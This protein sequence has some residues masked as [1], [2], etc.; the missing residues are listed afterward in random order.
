MARSHLG[1]WRRLGLITAVALLG[2]S[3]IS[4]ASLAR[5][6]G[7]DRFRPSGDG[8][9][10]ERAE[11]AELR[12]LQEMEDQAAEHP[13]TGAQSLFS[14]CRFSPFSDG[15]VTYDPLKPWERDVIVDDTTTTF[16]DGTTCYNPQNEQN[17]VV[18][19]T[20]DKNVVTSSNDYRYGS[21]V[22]Y[23]YVSDDGGASW[24]NVMLPGWTA[25]TGGQG[26]FAKSYCG[27]DPVLAFG[28]DG[29]L[30]FA[31]LVY[32]FDK[33]PRTLSGVAVSSSSDGGHTWTAPVM[34]AYNGTGNFFYDKE[35]I[36]VGNDGT[37]YLT[38]TK[39]YQGPL[40][41]G[42]LKSP[43]VMASSRNG[44]KSWSSVKEVSDAAHPYN[45]GSQVLQAPDGALYVAYEGATP[46]SGYNE[47]ALIVAR[48]TD[49]GTHFANAEVARV[50]DDY[51]C[52]PIQEPGGQDRQ[53]LS[54]MQLRINSY[55]SM[56]I[57]PA[58]GQIVIVWA[59]NR[60]DPA[61]GHGGAKYTGS[62]TSNQV[63][64]VTSS[65]GTGWS[66]VRQLTSG[67]D[68][69]YPSVG[70]NNG[71]IAIGYYTREYATSV[72]ANRECGIME[73]DTTT[74]ELVPPTDAGRASAVVC[75]D[76]AL[77]TSL[78]DFA[79]TTRV[80]SQSSN[81]YILFSGSFIGDYEGTAVTA[82]G[83]IY[84]T[85]TDFRGNPGVTL[86]NQDTMVGVIPTAD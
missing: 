26:L 1:P 20:N 37:V 27:G 46:G 23:A 52:Y 73:R 41:L 61:C 76:W 79:G 49:G 67:P 48:S 58:T 40:G 83:T 7:Q 66:A 15:T 42:Y 34:V 70:V 55:P 28:P 68:K 21:Y 60:A 43:I 74:G 86:P 12:N 62:G 45:Q 84:T 80:S 31:G 78:D 4:G 16:A 69:V 81:P 50:Y 10:G 11:L 39:F 2:A 19:P 30:Y 65:D 5:S 72:G 63:Q 57:D 32:N 29:T 56:A 22:C 77:K 8:D 47:D 13:V 33:F 38:W 75:L 44:G 71:L 17:I 14:R 6:P 25:P 59:D 85:W 18:N 54:N 53:T 82:D 35:W 3:T 64:M 51:D 9:A 24:D 36:G